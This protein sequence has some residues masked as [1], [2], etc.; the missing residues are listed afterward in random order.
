MWR[1]TSG[2]ESECFPKPD[3]KE[4]RMAHNWTYWQRIKLRYAEHLNK[5]NKY[6]WAQLVVW[7]LEYRWPFEKPRSKGVERIDNDKLRDCHAG[8][9]ATNLPCYCG[10]F[11]PEAR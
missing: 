10:K 11:R 8:T 9:C 4:D 1:T 7:A 3:N 6:C 5:G 2:F